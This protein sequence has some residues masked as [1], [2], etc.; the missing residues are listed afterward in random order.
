MG[1]D[2]GLFMP[3][4]LGH[5]VIHTHWVAREILHFYPEPG[6]GGPCAMWLRLRRPETQFFLFSNL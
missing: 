6:E 2:T 5:W 1:Q 4:G 3:N